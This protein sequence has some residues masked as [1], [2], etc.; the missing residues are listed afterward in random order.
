MKLFCVTLTGADDRTDPQDLLALSER[1]PFVEWGILLS[2]GR[3]GTA[4]YPSGD[5]LT[6]LASAQ[7]AGGP[8]NPAAGAPMRLAA[9]LCGRTMRDF[10]RGITFAHH[11]DSAWLAA[12]GLT[13]ETFGRSF[14]RA[15]VNMNARREGFSDTDLVEMLSGWLTTF[16]GALITQHN[17]ANVRVWEVLQAHELATVGPAWRPHQVLHDAS[18]GLGRT[19]DHWSRPIAGMLNGYA[20]GIGPDSVIDTLETLAPIVG[21]GFTWID[22]EGRLRDRDDAFDL[23]RVEDV[24]AQVERAGQTQGWL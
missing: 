24:L 1:F 2:A 21:D 17:P 14:Q 12:H 11:D 8:L 6:Q 22:M 9:H 13:A 20:G 18:G 5:W 23:A 19:P 15:Q 7:G 16:D 10:M 3:A 4:R